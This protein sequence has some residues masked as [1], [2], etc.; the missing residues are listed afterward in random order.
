MLARWAK[1]RGDVSSATV[2]KISATDKRISRESLHSCLE[3]LKNAQDENEIRRLTEELER[4]VFH[5]QY[6]NAEAQT[7][8]PWFRS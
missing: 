2:N 8:A 5:K 6:E 3:R 4:I 7:A 1:A